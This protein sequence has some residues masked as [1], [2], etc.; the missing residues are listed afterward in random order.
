MYIFP[1]RKLSG[2]DKIF[3]EKCRLEE[4]I[5]DLKEKAMHIRK[6]VL[7]FVRALELRKVP[8]H[9]EAIMSVLFELFEYSEEERGQMVDKKSRG[10]FGIFN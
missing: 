4:Q 2:D 8:R 3:R 10:F 7:E 1:E 6:I 9:V 5:L